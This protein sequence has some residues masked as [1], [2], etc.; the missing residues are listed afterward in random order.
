VGAGQGSFTRLLEERGFS[1][2]STDVTDEAVDVLKRVVAGPVV[3]ADASSLP[4]GD[5]EFDAVVAGEVLEHI[6]D[7]L[8][9]VREMRRVAPCIVASVPAHSGWFGPADEW[10]GHFRRYER[11]ALERLFSEAGLS[12]NVVPWGFPVAAAYHRFVYDQRAARMA[13]SGKRPSLALAALKAALQVDRLF[14]GVERGC[15]G[16][17]AVGKP[18]R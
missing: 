18:A 8:R 3:R 1:V 5:S 15:L 11:A 16:Y 10:A 4:F 13:T 7:D 2:T 6:D 9:A 17:I 14:V 12:V